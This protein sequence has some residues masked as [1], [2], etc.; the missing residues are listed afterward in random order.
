MR[1]DQA[2]AETIARHPDRAAVAFRGSR[3]T[4]GELGSRA[5]ELRRRLAA[6]GLSPGDRVVLWLEN[7]PEYIASY[8]AVLGA[9]AVVVGMHPQAHPSEVVRVIEHAGA[10]GLVYSASNPRTDARGVDDAA[11][12][13]RFDGREVTAGSSPTRPDAAPDGLAQI[14]YTS[15]STGRPKGVMLSHRNLLANTRSILEYLKLTADDRIVAVLP[16]VYSYGNS[17]ML[18]H[19]AVGGLLVLEN[20][21]LY[22]NVILDRMAEHAVTGFSGVASTY[23]LLVDQS[24]LAAYRFP[25]L[26][27]VTHA[28]GPM[29]SGLLAR[30][31]AAFAGKDVYV[32]YGQ[33]EASARLT[34]LPPGQLD[35][36]AGSAGRAIPGVTLRVVK[37]GGE[38]AKAGEVGEVLA[39]GDNIMMGYWG[40]PEASS[41]ALSDGWLHTGDIG[42]LDAEGYLTLVGRNSEIIKSGAFRVSPTE[43][44]DVL[45]AHPAVS[46]AGVVGI[47]DAVLGEAICG[48]VVPRAGRRPTNQE[49]LAYC[50]KH[51]APYKRPKV[52]CQTDALPK[53]P[54]GKVLRHGLR[55]I[56]R[57]AT[58]NAGGPG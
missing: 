50:A 24:N 26:R 39:S 49:L 36:K 56:G 23:A 9:G 54:S 27:Y 14:I 29:P 1:I 5:D 45:L 21:F 6:A 12:V 52:I 32:M 10:S 8:L 18:T 42:A 55:E 48:V 43:I 57:A 20:S 17:V 16:F 13:W 3:L 46:E 37:D 35:A 47:D 25:A 53:S 28:G 31:R 34:Y 44:E 7:S 51:L 19:L 30:V 33:T 15:G 38:P 2:V 41:R 11:L 4:Y 22:P 58:H 40:D